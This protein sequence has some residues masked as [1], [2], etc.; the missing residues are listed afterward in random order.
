MN[1]MPY[2]QMLIDFIMKILAFFKKS[3]NTEPE[4]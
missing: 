2:I 1:I 3:D 4:A